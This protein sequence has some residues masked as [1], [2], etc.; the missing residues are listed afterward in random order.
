MLCL[1]QVKDPASRLLEGG[2]LGNISNWRK[3]EFVR[4]F[5]EAE[6]RLLTGGS[7][8]NFEYDQGSFEVCSKSK[9]I[10]WLLARVSP[11]VSPS[12]T[13]AG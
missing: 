7:V 12:A 10:L 11:S 1:F 3:A 6:Q 13:L 9:S 2:M 8:W 4:P 5:S